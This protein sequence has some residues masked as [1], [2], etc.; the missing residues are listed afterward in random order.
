MLRNTFLLLF[1]WG[2]F[3]LF[4]CTPSQ[5]GYIKKVINDFTTEGFLT[6]DIFQV[7]CSVELQPNELDFFMGQLSAKN[8]KQIPRLNKS[9]A[10]TSVRSRLLQQCQNKTLVLLAQ[11]RLAMEKKSSTSFSVLEKEK[12]IQH[13]FKTF[14]PGKIVFE[15][16]KDAKL[17]VAYRI[18]KPNLIALVNKVKIK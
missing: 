12:K 9:F 10:Q 16:I 8:S 14:L 4:A 1:L 2:S 7:V 15:E 13:L 11:N 3:F 18:E 17:V 6:H 5:D